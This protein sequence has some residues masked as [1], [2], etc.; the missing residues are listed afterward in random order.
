[1]YFLEIVRFVDGLPECKVL[2]G[3]LKRSGSNG[4]LVS[5]DNRQIKYVDAAESNSQ[6]RLMCLDP[7]LE[8]DGFSVVGPYIWN[9]LPLDL[10]IVLARDSEGTFYTLWKTSFPPRLDREHL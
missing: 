1:M 10:R 7:N 6:F 8:C 9:G 2:S 4:D 3:M 5:A